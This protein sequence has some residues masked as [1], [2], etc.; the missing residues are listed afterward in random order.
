MKI[1]S[2]LRLTSPLWIFLSMTSHSSVPIADLKI[3]HTSGSI[4]LSPCMT[5]P[6]AGLYRY[7]LIT[8]KKG[9]NG[10]T[11]N[12]QGGQQ[13][14]EANQSICLGS[15]QLNRHPDD[16]VEATLSIYK[17][18]TLIDSQSRTVSPETE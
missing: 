7:L 4:Q 15:V 1:F 5:S 8:L 6:A 2:A 14:L 3:Q 18:N 17:D 11:N 10:S 16:I 9:P 13:Q 12:H